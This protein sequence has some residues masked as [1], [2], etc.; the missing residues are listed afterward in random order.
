MPE[1]TGVQLAATIKAEWPRLP[2]IV[3]TGY[4]E[5]PAGA[6]GDLLKL[7][8]P[9]SQSQLEETVAIATERE[10]SKRGLRRAVL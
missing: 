7:A 3:A 1:M 9:F 4:A 2:I 10:D 5:L 6:G 8:K